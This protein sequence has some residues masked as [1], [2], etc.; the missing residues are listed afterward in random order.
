MNLLHCLLRE[1][2]EGMLRSESVLA[3]KKLAARVNYPC[4]PS[5]SRDLPEHGSQARCVTTAAF[6]TQDCIMEWW[7]ETWSVSRVNMITPQT[8]RETAQVFLCSSSSFRFIPTH[9]KQSSDRSPG[10]LAQIPPQT[11]GPRTSSRVF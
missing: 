6:A 7:D 5:L 9:K 1:M 11:L 8:T 2:E 4:C 3:R 10:V